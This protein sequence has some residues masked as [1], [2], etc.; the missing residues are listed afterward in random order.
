MSMSLTAYPK[1]LVVREALYR[2]HRELHGRSFD[3]IDIV[4]GLFRAGLIS[5]LYCKARPDQLRPQDGS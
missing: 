2:K 3:A 1:I 4:T 5:N